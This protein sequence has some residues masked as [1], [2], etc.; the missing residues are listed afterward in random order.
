MIP[1]ATSQKV[2]MLL[3]ATIQ[4]F[5]ICGKAVYLVIK[6]RRWRDKATQSVEIKSDYSFIAEG[7]KLTVELSDFLKG[8]DRDPRRYDE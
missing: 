7:S 8:T 1:L 6:R 5:P 3:L 2:F 4:D